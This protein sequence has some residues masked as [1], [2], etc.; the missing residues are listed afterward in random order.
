MINSK[1]QI[2]D[3]T[4]V[5]G[6]NDNE[7]DYGELIPNGTIEGTISFEEPVDDDKLVLQ[8]KSTYGFSSESILFECKLK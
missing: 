4:L 8:Y 6:A 1:G 3:E 2:N 5:L 7:L